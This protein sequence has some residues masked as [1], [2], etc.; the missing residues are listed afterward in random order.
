[1]MRSFKFI[2][3]LHLMHKIIGITYLLCWAL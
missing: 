1:V 2:F 3:I